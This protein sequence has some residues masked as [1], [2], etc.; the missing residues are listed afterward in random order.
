MSHSGSKLE[1]EDEEIRQQRICSLLEQLNS[2]SSSPPK[3]TSNA[4]PPTFDFGERKTYAVDPPSELLAR[5]QDFLPRLK[6]ENDSLSQRIRDNP[7]SVDIE[8]IEEDAEQYIEMNLGL[9]VLETRLRDSD[10]HSD[11]EDSESEDSSSSSSSSSPSSVSSSE[12]DSES[13]GS[14]SDSSSDSDFSSIG[15]KAISSRPLKPLPRR[16]AQFDI[17][18]LPDPPSAG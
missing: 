11:D 6:E 1:I 7:S 13:D 10:S 18:M 15:M 14:H 9:G 17:D 16:T 5:I 2:S 4:A 3:N 8:N 12:S